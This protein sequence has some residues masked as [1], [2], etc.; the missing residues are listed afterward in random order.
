MK[1]EVVRL[2]KMIPY[3]LI[4]WISAV[5]THCIYLVSSIITVHSLVSRNFGLTH[6]SIQNVIHL[7][8]T[9]KLQDPLSSSTIQIPQQKNTL[10]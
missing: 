4:H 9:Y 7:P 8:E 1:T 10:A 5:F 3:V 6:D 2:R